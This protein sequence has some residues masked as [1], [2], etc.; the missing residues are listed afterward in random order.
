MQLNKNYQEMQ[1]KCGEKKNKHQSQDSVLVTIASKWVITYRANHKLRTLNIMTWHSM[2]E[3]AIHLLLN[4]M[5]LIFIAIRLRFKFSLPQIDVNLHFLKE[6]IIM[7]LL[8]LFF[9]FFARR[10]MLF[11]LSWIRNPLLQIFVGM[12]FD[13]NL[14]RFFHHKCRDFGSNFIS[15]KNMRTK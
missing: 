5:H 6:R 4:E 13:F 15:I 7:F 11:F 9:F 14:F 2:A 12:F 10:Q 1:T 3:P 8:F